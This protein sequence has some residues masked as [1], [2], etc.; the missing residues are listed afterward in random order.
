[1]R[2]GE[3]ALFTD[4]PDRLVDFYTRVLGAQ[5]ASRW[6]GGAV[7]RVRDVTLLIHR[8]MPAEQGAPANTD[9]FA[10]AVADVDDEWR[11]LGGSG[12]DGDE[13]RNY[14]WGRAAYLRDPDGRLVELQQD[15][16]GAAG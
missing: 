9:H 5:P 14:A 4:D 16:S 15:E 7:F 11:A 1:M 2:L 6:D 3:L 13:P 10:F 8:R 12:V